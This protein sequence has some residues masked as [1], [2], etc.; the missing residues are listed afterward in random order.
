MGDRVPIQSFSES[1]GVAYARVGRS[2]VGSHMEVFGCLLA[3]FAEDLEELTRV[4]A[5]IKATSRVLKL[6]VYFADT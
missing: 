6:K 2:D 4:S 5:S 1:L 3:T